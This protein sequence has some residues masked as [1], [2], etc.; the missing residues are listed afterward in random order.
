[1]VSTADFDSARFGSNPNVPA[2]LGL[3][4]FTLIVTV[5]ST[6]LL[7]DPRDVTYIP[8]FKTEALCQAAGAKVKEQNKSL[9]SGTV[10]R[11]TC[12]KSS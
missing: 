7:S 2:N 4:M 1:M 9:F 3:S 11:Y 12:V 8:H 10:T 5:I 6:G